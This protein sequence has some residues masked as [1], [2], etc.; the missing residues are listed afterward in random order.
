MNAREHLII[1]SLTTA[2]LFVIIHFATK[3]LPITPQTLIMTVVIAYVYSLL[4]D[5][6]TRASMIVWSFLGIGISGITIAIINNYYHFLNNGTTIMIASCVLLICVFA[7]Q[8][9]G[10]RGFIHSLSFDA[11]ASA[12]IYLI[13]PSIGLC[14]I[15]FATFWSHLICDEESFKVT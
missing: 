14:V 8:F 6:D 1:G 9:I 5:I 12:A 4:P 10:H 15:A 3:Y 13:V 7:A 2:I 11:I